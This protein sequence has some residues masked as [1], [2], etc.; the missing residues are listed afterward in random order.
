LT[1]LRNLKQYQDSSP[2]SLLICKLVERLPFRK[3]MASQLAGFTF[4][5]AIIAP[6]A[7][8]AIASRQTQYM[9]D[10]EYIDAST[11]TQSRYRWPL[12]RIGITQYFSRAHPGIDLVSPTGTPVYSISEGRV[13]SVTKTPGQAYGIHIIINHDNGTK[14][15]YAH[16]SKVS[17]V[18]GQEVYKNTVV[19]EVGSTGRSTGYHLHL[20]IYQKDEAINPVDVLPTLSSPTA[21]AGVSPKPQLQAGLVQQ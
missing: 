13:A 14:S 8:R 17:V 12:S 3:L 6:Q 4:V 11:V 9:P 19:G 10:V 1:S 15:L 16:L 7:S 2:V 18:E 21:P 20:E 5:S